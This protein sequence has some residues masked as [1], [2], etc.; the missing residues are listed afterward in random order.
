MD[1]LELEL[2][3]Q[4]DDQDKRDISPDELREQMAEKFNIDAENESELLDSIVDHEIEQR[5]K[6]STAIRQKQDWRKKA[7]EQAGK[8]SDN[9]KDNPTKGDTPNVESLVDERLRQR[10]LDNLDLPDE[11]KTEI[12][13]MSKY[14]GISV[15]EAS[16]LPYIAS[17]IRE[18]EAQQ[19]ADGAL[20]SRGNRGGRSVK[21]ASKAPSAEDYDFS[22]EEDRERWDKDTKSYLEYKRKNG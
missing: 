1:K 3:D 6:L 17:M 16:K 21:D 20:P 11:I 7:T 14:K 15:R 19:D 12:A 10:D 9:D 13:D 4:I 5:K 2:E 18:H 22:K 8:K